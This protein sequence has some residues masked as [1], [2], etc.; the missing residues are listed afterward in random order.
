MDWWITNESTQACSVRQVYFALFSVGCTAAIQFSA[1]MHRAHAEKEHDAGFVPPRSNWSTEW[2]GIGLDAFA[3]ETWSSELEEQ[4]RV[5]ASRTM[6]A[7]ID[8]LMC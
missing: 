5:A 6:P 1:Q 2:V 7:L 3:I 4:L 8:S